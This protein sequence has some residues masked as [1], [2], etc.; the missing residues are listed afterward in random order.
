MHVAKPSATL[1]VPKPRQLAQHELNINLKGSPGITYRVQSWSG[2]YTMGTSVE[3]TLES[4]QVPELHSSKPLLWKYLL[5][6]TL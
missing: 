2:T 6:R 1:N 4:Q 3:P 5:N